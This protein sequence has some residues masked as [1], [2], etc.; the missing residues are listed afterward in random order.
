VRRRKNLLVNLPFIATL[1]KNLQVI[2]LQIDIDFSV[3]YQIACG[4]IG[5][6]T[7]EIELTPLTD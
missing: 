4:T 6:G 2:E 5:S 3:I 7:S 1:K